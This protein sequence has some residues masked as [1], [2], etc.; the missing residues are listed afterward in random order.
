MS[1][2]MCICGGSEAEGTKNGD[3]FSS[4]RC[5]TLTFPREAH[6]GTTSGRSLMWPVADPPLASLVQGKADIRFTQRLV[7]GPNHIGHWTK[8]IGFLKGKRV[9]DY[10]C[11]N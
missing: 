11:Q 4:L 2:R 3:N 5:A 9:L 6:S 7:D 1:R 10:G 8:E